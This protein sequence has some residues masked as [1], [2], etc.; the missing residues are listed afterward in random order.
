MSVSFLC[1]VDVDGDDGMS[2]GPD[3]TEVDSQ[4]AAI[5]RELAEVDV[6]WKV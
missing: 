4:A 2:S 1:Q 6:A 5:K 3:D